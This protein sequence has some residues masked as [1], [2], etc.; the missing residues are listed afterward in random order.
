MTFEFENGIF[1]V[2]SFGDDGVFGI[3]L[4]AAKPN[5]SY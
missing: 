1:A 3:F 4:M 2:G 5:N